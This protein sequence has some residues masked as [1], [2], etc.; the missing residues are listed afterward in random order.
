MTNEKT[1]EELSVDRKRLQD[2]G[3]LP[4]WLTTNAW[5]LL[6]D[7]YI[8]E[9]NP[10]LKHIYRRIAKRA[11]SYLNAPEEWEDKF[12]DLFWKGYLCPSTP[13]LSNMGTETGMAVSC[14]GQ[15]ISDSVN[16][17]YESL[18]ESAMLTKNGFGTSGYLGNIR[19]RGATI[20]GGSKASGVL[21]VFKMFVQMSDDISQG[22]QR[23][24]AWAGYI[25]IEH[26]DFYELVN[27]ITKNPDSANIGWIVSDA[28]IDKLDAGDE[29]SINRFQK[30]MKLK[31]L[32]GKGYF[33]FVDKVNELSPPMYKDKG[34]K[35]KTSNLC[36]TGDTRIIIKGDITG[37]LNTSMVGF[38][39]YLSKTDD[40]ENWHVWSYNIE[41][42]TNEWKR[43]L[44]TAQMSK[45]A[46]LMR[47]TDKPSGVSI[48][49][50]PD[51]QIFTRNRGYVCA[52]D[53]VETDEM[54]IDIV[55]T[56]GN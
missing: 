19:H 29:D 14:S 27:Y 30:A 1:Y 50:T 51:H 36:L 22:A 13:V 43:L 40:I 54:V 16:S 49:C 37:V 5:Q 32:T 55:E 34:L 39:N 52:K 44:K 47:I 38:N 12:F 25:E 8:N 42:Q 6:Y 26:G 53:L 4:E 41:T 56:K 31:M 33:F 20:K 15:N 46:R 24:G 7:K 45:S 2:E 10:N 21:P 9:D 17:F 18:K 35:V 11:A 23:R 48:K 28:F 3:L